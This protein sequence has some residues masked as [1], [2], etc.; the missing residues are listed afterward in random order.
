[1]EGSGPQTFLAASVEDSLCSN[2]LVWPPIIH[3]FPRQLYSSALTT[4]RRLDKIHLS[5][6]HIYGQPRHI[7]SSCHAAPLWPH[8]VAQ[9]LESFMPLRHLSYGGYGGYGSSPTFGFIIGMWISNIDEC[10][11]SNVEF[12]FV[13]LFE[14]F[15]CRLMS[16]HTKSWEAVGHPGQECRF[17][18]WV[19]ELSVR[20]IASTMC[21]LTSQV[22]VHLLATFWGSGT[23]YFSC[24][25]L[26]SQIRPM[27]FAHTLAQNKHTYRTEQFQHLHVFMQDLNVLAGNMTILTYPDHPVLHGSPWHRDLVRVLRV[28]PSCGGGSHHWSRNRSYVKLYHPTVSVGL[29][30]VWQMMQMRVVYLKPSV[31]R[32]L[33]QDWFPTTETWCHS[34]EA[35]DSWSCQIM[36]GCSWQGT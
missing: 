26:A 34:C 7:A 30:P 18:T 6:P 25:V 36:R 12:L 3:R 9:A 4:L 11:L 27:I 33:C 28:L 10:S 13:C 24:I 5:A 23:G 15:W 19:G 8:T 16:P 22:D 14:Q 21:C 35:W 20:C 31:V 29:F 2:A 1:M 32:S 17:W